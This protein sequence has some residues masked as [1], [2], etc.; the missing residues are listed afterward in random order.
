MSR[1]ISVRATA[2]S[3]PI[4]AAAGSPCPITSPTTRAVRPP[5]SAI[6]S[7]QSP[8]TPWPAVEGA[9]SECSRSP[10]VTGVARGSRLRCNETTCSRSRPY[11]RALSMKTAAFEA[12]CSARARSVEENGG[13]P[14]PRTKSALPSSSPRAISGTAR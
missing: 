12:S 7:Y 11:S 4:V 3:R 5:G 13:V 6:T 2:R 1:V 10:G 14:G 9:Y 8:P